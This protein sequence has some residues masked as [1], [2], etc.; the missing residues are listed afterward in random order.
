MPSATDGVPYLNK[1]PL[2]FCSPGDKN[3]CTEIV[4]DSFTGSSETSAEAYR[5]WRDVHQYYEEHSRSKYDYSGND[6]YSLAVDHE[7]RTNGDCPTAFAWPPG[8]QLRVKILSG[9]NV[10]PAIEQ[11]IKTTVNGWSAGLTETLTFQ[12][13]S[14]CEQADIRISFYNDK[15]N[16]SALGARAALYDEK[17]ATMNLALGGWRGKQTVFTHGNIARAAA[18]LFGHALGL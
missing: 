5:K 7:V 16:W 15:P 9:Q 6:H 4:K 2:F 14:S 10:F 12:W 1:A 17:N 18:H 11:I 8:T 13:V 3:N